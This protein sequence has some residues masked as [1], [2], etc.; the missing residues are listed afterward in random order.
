MFERADQRIVERTGEATQQIA[1]TAKDIG[2]RLDMAG[3]KLVSTSQAITVRVVENVVEAQRRLSA[4]A[5]AAGQQV[6]N[7]IAESEAQ[8]AERTSMVE[9]TFTAVGQHIATTTNDAARAIGDNTRELGNVLASGSDDI[10]RILEEKAR[11]L[12]ERFA[13]GGTELERSMSAA[14]EKA[15]ERMRAENAAFVDALSRQTAESLDMVAGAKRSLSGEANDLIERLA[16]SNGQLSELIDLAATSL[17]AVDGKLT[18]STQSFAASTERAAQ[19]F[20]SSSR[21]LESNTG[22]LTEM[23]SETLKAVAGIATR[24]EEHSKLLSSASDI[25]G[26]AQTNLVTTLDDRQAALEDLAVGLVKKSEDIER[27]MRSFESILEHSLDRAESRAKESSEIIRSSMVDVVES[28]TQ[29]FADATVEIRRTSEIIR[30]EL[31]ETRTALKKGVIDMPAEAK[32]ST[33]AIRRAV[34]EQINALKELSAIVTKSGR[35]GGDDNRPAPRPAPAP[36]RAEEPPRM[37]LRSRAEPDG[38]VLLRGSLDQDGALGRGWDPDRRPV[39]REEPVMARAPAR[40]APPASRPVADMLKS[41]SGDIARAIDLD[42]LSEM[43]DRRQHGERDVFSR[44]LYTLKGQQT[45]DDIQRKYKLDPEFHAAV[46]RYAE[47]FE[48]RLATA[49]RD[50]A[51]TR[52]AFLSDAGKVYL[53]LAHAAGRLR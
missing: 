36:V 30:S 11:P 38:D 32:E 47:D 27:L 8:F 3:D 15:T 4:A 37:P 14:S 25:L 50:D 18:N 31:D 7:K 45:F 48:R 12:V 42:T 41:I 43:L 24:F 5:D 52:R 28:A 33:T 40:E 10:A 49:S 35:N 17:N 16:Q 44:R 23:T 34:T 51:A 9:R 13:A 2:D 19:T 46:N 20:A 29:R 21:L 53:M 1:A 6:Q 22:R 26:S 39:E